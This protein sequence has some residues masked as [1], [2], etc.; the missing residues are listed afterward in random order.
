MGLTPEEMQGLTTP[1][2]TVG[3]ISEGRPGN[4]SKGGFFFGDQSSGEGF[5]SG[6][7]GANQGFKEAND[8]ISALTKYM[9]NTATTGTQDFEAYVENNPKMYANW[10]NRNN[11]SISLEQW[12]KNHYEASGKAAGREVPSS[13]TANPAAVTKIQGV[14][15][16]ITPANMG[17]DLP[18]YKTFNQS[19]EWTIG[20]TVAQITGAVM[21][22]YGLST[23]PAAGAAANSSPVTT[24]A[25]SPVDAALSTATGTSIGTSTAAGTSILQSAVPTVLDTALTAGLAGTGG[26]GFME[27]LDTVETVWKGAN[28]IK[29]TYDAVTG[30]NNTAI[31]TAIDE[32]PPPD[33]GIIGGYEPPEKLNNFESVDVGVRAGN[34]ELKTTGGDKVYNDQGLINKEYN[35][36]DGRY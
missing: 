30:S 23:T 21:V 22:G 6:I 20:G 18:E 9:L 16:S 29:D 36:M 25:A 13:S 12:G 15:P 2:I 26:M 4:V 32:P 10:Q 3:V 5:L 17:F 14:L 28:T 35:P 11:R 8:G 34:T 1:G 24:I 27:I 31:D 19:N 7:E 33:T